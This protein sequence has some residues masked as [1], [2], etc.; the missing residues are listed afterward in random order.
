V[1]V[2]VGLEGEAAV[3]RVCDTG[4]GIAEADL[5]QVFSKFFRGSDVKREA[6]PGVGLGLA[7]TKTIVDAHHGR[8]EVRSR[9]AEGTTFEVRLP[10]AV[11]PAL[12]AA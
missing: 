5:A 7:I 3:V 11:P 12:P 8:I 9:L 2:T 1:Q 10:I 6:I 4:R